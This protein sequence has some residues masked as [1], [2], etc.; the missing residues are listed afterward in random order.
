MGLGLLGGLI[1]SLAGVGGGVVF[2]PALALVLGLSQVSAEATSLL[3][4]VP[5]AIF[6]T[7]Q[8]RGSGEV[9]IRA[10]LIIG[11]GALIPA[12]TGAFAAHYIPEFALRAVFATLMIL[13]AIR[14]WMS[15]RTA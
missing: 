2:V 13:I 3:A 11:L 1:A 4:I 8:Q 14:V 10:A 5:V 15:A 9:H 6:A 7:W 12:I